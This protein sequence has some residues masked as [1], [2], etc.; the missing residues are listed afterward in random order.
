M[1]AHIVLA[2]RRAFKKEIEAQFGKAH[3]ESTGAARATINK[4]KNKDWR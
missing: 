2:R 4:M 3:A 1:Q